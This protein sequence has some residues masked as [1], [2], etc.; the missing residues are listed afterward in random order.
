MPLLTEPLDL[1]RRLAERHTDLL[2]RDG[3]AS[4]RQLHE[5]HDVHPPARPLQK[6]A[7]RLRRF[8]DVKTEVHVRR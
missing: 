2:H 3:G 8:A 4:I 7:P 5:L 1:L 6:K